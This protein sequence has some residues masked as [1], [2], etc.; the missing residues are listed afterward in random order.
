MKKY[1]IVILVFLFFCELD[2]AQEVYVS[3]R[4]SISTTFNTINGIDARKPAFSYV[5]NGSPSLHIGSFVL[6]FGVLFS[7]YRRNFSQPFNQYGI[8]PKYKGIKLHIGHRSINWSKYSMGGHRFYG[9]GGETNLGK[10]RLGYVQ[11]RFLKATNPDTTTNYRIAS[12]PSFKRTGYAIKLGFGNTKT[13]IDFV[14]FKAKD[15]IK[16]LDS[17]QRL[18]LKPKENTVLGLKGLIK[19][20]KKWKFKLDLGVSGLNRDSRNDD[21]SIDS[22]SGVI[23]FAKIIFT[24]KVSA[25]I[26]VAKELSLNYKSKR[27]G[28]DMKYKN[29]DPNYTSLG[30]YYLRT[31]ISHISVGS[32]ISLADRKYYFSF[33]YGIENDNVHEQKLQ[34]TK[35]TVF[36]SNI[37]LRPNKFFGLMAQYSNFGLLQD[38]KL[39]SISDTTR[40]NNIMKSLI[41]N[42]NVNIEAAGLNHNISLIYSNQTLDD[43]NKFTV[44]YTSIKTKSYTINY[45]ANHKTGWSGRIG[46][47]KNTSILSAGIA[48]SNGFSFGLNKRFNKKGISV[49]AS[50]F[51]NQNKYENTKNGFTSRISSNLKW[52]FFKN[53]S[54]TIS[55]YRLVNKSLHNE[56][57]SS[58]TE[59]NIRTTYSYR[60][61]TKKSRK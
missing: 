3:G 36:S 13:Y 5:L 29:I 4:V 18:R 44:V 12:R 17:V 8:S 34:T 37:L 60:F 54:I 10:I 57:S 61:T 43:K 6:P 7:N 52:S 9:L 35:R 38:S 49:N 42:P 21:I 39:I 50:F 22:T 30:T 47:N 56:V 15:D 40:L 26:C 55:Y 45:I 1:L 2:F 32:F 59:N 11:G 23:K 20:S 46:W 33:R 27:F 41:I 25:Q 14:Y 24:P 19:I 28:I 16:S 58:F 48:E 31:D 51:Y 53:H